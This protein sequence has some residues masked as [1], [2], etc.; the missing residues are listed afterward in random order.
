MIYVNKELKKAVWDDINRK[1]VSPLIVRSTQ[2]AL[3]NIINYSVTK[4][5]PLTMIAIVNNLGP[6]ITV[7]LAF[8]VLK[9]RLKGFEIIM[10][11]LTVAGILTVVVGG[12]STDSSDTGLPDISKSTRYIMYGV[13]FFNPFLSAF[14]T[15]SMR[16]MKKFHEAV[17]SW[18][19]NWAIGITS[20]IVLLAMGSGFKPIA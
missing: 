5:L 16:K 8:L 11:A 3:T 10:I 6:P 2:G 13:L 7:F 17:V 15:I 19:L 20:I 14:G 18:Y 4:F 12:E 1:N 9:E